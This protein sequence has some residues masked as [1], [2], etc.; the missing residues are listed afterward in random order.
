VVKVRDGAQYVHHT[1][2]LDE[3]FS[4]FFALPTRTAGASRE[5]SPSSNCLRH[6]SVTITEPF[7]S[8]M[9]HVKMS[10][11]YIIAGR[12]GSDWTSTIPSSSVSLVADCVAF[13]RCVQTA[14]C[15]WSGVVV[16]VVASINIVNLSRARL[17]LRWATESGFNSRCW[18]FIAACNQPA[19]QGQLSL[20]SLWGR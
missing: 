1:T 18:T 20:P 10:S 8:L 4:S 15:W 16:S 13:C 9:H 3:F 19:T 7:M 14:N 5:S 6:Y 12:P 11:V 2:G 17:V